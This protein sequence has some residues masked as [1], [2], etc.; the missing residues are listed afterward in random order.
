MSEENTINNLERNDL[1]IIK[2]RFRHVKDDDEKKS[3]QKICC[4]YNDIFRLPG[5]KLREVNCAQH[6]INTPSVTKEAGINIKQ[7]RI[8]YIHQFEIKKQIQTML[9]QKIIR[10]SD[11]PWNFPILMVPKKLDASNVRKWRMCIDYRKL[12]NVTIGDSCPLP[13]IQE[14]LDK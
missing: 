14:I 7:Y 8:P 3:I 11:S 9:D 13:N 1:G 5:D 4:D 6:V 2:L 10:H 12:N